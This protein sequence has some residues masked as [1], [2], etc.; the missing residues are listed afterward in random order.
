VEDH[1]RRLKPAN[2]PFT[3]KQKLKRAGTWRVQVRYV[4]VAPYKASTATSKTMRV[5]H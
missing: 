5:K 1:P 2:K 4:N 3:F